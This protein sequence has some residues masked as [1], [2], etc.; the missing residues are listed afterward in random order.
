MSFLDS[1]FD[2]EVVALEVAKRGRGAGVGV[3]V[4]REDGVPVSMDE[5]T[6]LRN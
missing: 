6:E 5:R 3:G 1:G 2:A 4:G